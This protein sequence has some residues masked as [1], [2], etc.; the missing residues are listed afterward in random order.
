[1]THEQKRRPVLITIVGKQWQQ[2][3]EPSKIRLIT[4]GEW[5][6][7]ADH[8]VLT[9]QEGEASGL[10]DTRTT[11]VLHDDESVSMLREGENSMRMDFRSGARHIT[12]ML[13][14]FGNLTMGLFTNEVTTRSDSEGGEVHISYAMDSSQSKA[15]NTKLDISYRYV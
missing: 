8:S 5:E 14:P 9:Y 6:R 4:E 11:L 7:R 12:N 3:D 13:T 2:N 1:M 15:L 10:G